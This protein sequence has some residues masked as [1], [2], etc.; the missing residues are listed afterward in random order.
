M[1]GTIFTG[2]AVNIYAG[3]TLAKAIVLYDKCRMIPT[4]GMTISKMMKQ[5][6]A[7][8][9]KK[10]KA[11]DYEGAAVAL[12]AWVN[13]QVEIMRKDGTGEIKAISAS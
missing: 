3:L 1:S 5:A 8:T 12:G 7:V 9:G 6:S 11:R 4:R 10:F 13:E 2:T